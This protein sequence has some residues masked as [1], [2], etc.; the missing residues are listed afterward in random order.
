[1]RITPSILSRRLIANINTSSWRL[2]ESLER[3]GTGKRITR[4]SDDPVGVATALRLRSDI[5]I[6]DRFRVNGEHAQSFL[7]A[8]ETALDGVTLLLQRTRELAVQGASGT[9]TAVDQQ[10]IGKEVEQLL[11]EMMQLA[12]SSYNGLYIFGGNRTGSI[13]FTAIGVPSSGVTY[14]GDRGNR[15]VEIAPAENVEIN[16]SGD[17]VFMTGQNLFG[18]LID[19]RDRLNVGDGQGVSMTSM[20]NI[21]AGLDKVLALRAS[22]GAK[23]NRLERHGDRLR[24]NFTEQTSRLSE[25][26]DAD[27]ASTAIEASLQQ[28][29][30]EA[31]LAVGAR[32]LQQPSLFNYLV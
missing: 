31:A 26:E 15:L 6:T 13:P 5:K 17:E 21:D 11:D 30:L 1:M 22:G 8:T 16:V 12:N 25:V 4:P 19:L 3:Q 27:L 9:L 32:I 7:S 2:R 18:T 10:A 20:A 24:T 14:N 28:V 23:I 29:A